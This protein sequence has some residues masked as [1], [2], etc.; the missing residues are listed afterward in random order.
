MPLL[1]LYYLYICFFYL[2][3]NHA[4]VYGTFCSIN[5]GFVRA[6]LTSEYN[7]AL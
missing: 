6:T 2:G 7:D 5:Q 1:L 3:Q 4:I